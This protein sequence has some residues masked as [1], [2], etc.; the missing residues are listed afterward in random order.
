MERNKEQ[1]RKQTHDF[2]RGP[3]FGPL[4]RFALP[5]LAALFLQTMYGAVDLLVVGQFGGP[6]AQEYVS[7]VSTGGMLMQ[8]LT[9]VISGLAMGLTVSVA[10]RIGAGRKDEAGQIIGCGIW[11]FG[12]IALVLTAVML[13]SSPALASLMQVPEKAVPHTVAYLRI[14]SGGLLFIIAYNLLG[15]VFR[16]IGDS[17]IP[18]I[19][20]VIACVMN[21]AGDLLLVAVFHLGAVGAAAATVAAQAFSVVFSLQIIRRRELPFVLPR[22]EIRPQPTLA[23]R[24]LR[25]GIPVALQD[26]LV[27]ISFLVILSIVNHLGLTASAGVGVAEKL[28]GFLM[29]V[30]SAYMQSMSSF[31]AQNIGAG[32]QDRADRALFCFIGYFNGCARTTFVMLQGIAGAFGVRIPVSYYMSRQ[33]PVSLFHMGLA[34]PAS[35]LVQILLCG[36]YFLLLRRS[37]KA[38]NPGGGDAGGGDAGGQ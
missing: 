24:I 30:P 38:G 11:L 23:A 26:L 22:S 15:S 7:A 19:S 8:T 4:V 9:I 16:G 17:V 2:T 14:C 29:L 25:T 10:L 37:R 3:I 18:L 1:N 13:L 6:R 21:I 34:T 28:C 31:V 20:V 32:R 12:V 33:V 35:S 36:A 27:S 5:V